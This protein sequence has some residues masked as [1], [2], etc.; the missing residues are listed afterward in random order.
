MEKALATIRGGHVE[1]DAPVDWPEGT[2]L[3][4]RPVP[5]PGNGAPAL[6]EAP[7]GVREEFLNA[8]NDPDRFGLEESLWP[9]TA[10]ERAIWLNWFES[11]EP[12]EFTPEEEAALEADRK[13]SKELQKQLTV[14]NWQELET[15]FE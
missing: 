4:V 6:P 10:E 14:K 8:M 11:T 15:L 1:L 7:P 12:L 2:R 13:A 5:V 9:Q 3:E